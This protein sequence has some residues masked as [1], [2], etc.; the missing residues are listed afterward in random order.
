MFKIFKL[1]QKCE[2]MVDPY[3]LDSVTNGRD[4]ILDHIEH[5]GNRLGNSIYKLVSQVLGCL[6]DLG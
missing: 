1:F 6:T 2:E 3:C 4:N 5:V